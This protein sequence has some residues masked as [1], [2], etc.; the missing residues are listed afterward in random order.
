MRPYEKQIKFDKN[1]KLLIGIGDSFCAGE[2]AESV[3][4]WEKHNW[5]K[6]K[7]KSDPEVIN[8]GYINS[9][10][11]VLKEEYLKDYISL[12]LGLPGR[13]NRYAI[14]ELFSNPELGI[15]NAGE[16]IVIFVVSGLERLDFSK[17]IINKFEHTNTLWPFYD[18]PDDVGYGVLTKHGIPIYNDPMIIGEFIMDMYM[19]TNWCQLNN[20][21]LLFINGFTKLV[22]RVNM[23]NNLL[24]NRNL[25]N[26]NK[27][28][29]N[30]LFKNACNMVN[31][32]PWHLQIKLMGHNTIMDFILT[33]QGREDLV[34]GFYME[35][36]IDK[37]SEDDY[38][39]KCLHPTKKSHKLIANIVY[40]Y[41]VKYDELVPIDYS[42]ADRKEFLNYY[43]ILNDGNFNK[44]KK[45]LI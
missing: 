37:H 13:G 3:E 27:N 31:K 10:I 35:Y 7:I 14:R 6:N 25:K 30:F 28:I 45:S 43:N 24:D 42:E 1:T 11:N 26:T 5:D 15:E 36:K 12:N 9:F 20:A 33:K 40:D 38:I 34:N 19:L 17:D 44:H 2:G 23:I 39:S 18:K 22:D 32:I 16:K 4:L 29:F 21:K 41:I 8:E